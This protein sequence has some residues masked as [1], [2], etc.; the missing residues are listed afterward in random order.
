MVRLSI[1]FASFQDVGKCD[2]RMQW[3]NRW[4]KWTSGLLGRC[5]RHSFGMPSIPQAVF[6]FKELSKFCKSQGHKVSHKNAFRWSLTVLS[7]LRSWFSSHRSCGVNR[8]SKQSAIALALSTGW[9]CRPIR[10]WMGSWFIPVCEEPR[11]R[12]Y[13]L[14][15]Q[16]GVC[17]FRFSPFKCL[18]SDYAS[19]FETQ[20]TA[21]L[22]LGSLVS[23]T[24]S[25]S[26]SYTWTAGL[27]Q[28][29][30]CLI[31]TILLVDS[32]YAEAIEA[33]KERAALSTSAPEL[34]SILGDI[35]LR[36]GF[37]TAPNL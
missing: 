29:D 18:F 12:P 6:N 22:H 7:T 31:L 16:L 37:E 4:V 17:K 21:C 15:C 11:N 1:T 23:C 34:I 24:N 35:K 9:Y 28:V 33:V 20:L 3:L 25:S 32:L 5:L 13:C 2:R 27:G 10:P 8:F 26:F 19:D 14:R 30:R 36:L